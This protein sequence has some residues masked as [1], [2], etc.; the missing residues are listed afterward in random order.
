MLLALV[1][2]RVEAKRSKDVLH[3][4]SSHDRLEAGY[5]REYRELLQKLE[6]GDTE[7]AKQTVCMAIATFYHVQGSRDSSQE[8]AAEKQKIDSQAKSSTILAAT[9]KKT[10]DWR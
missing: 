6:A 4:L 3:F 7:S 10:S 9:I 1:A 8:L 2:Y 5:D